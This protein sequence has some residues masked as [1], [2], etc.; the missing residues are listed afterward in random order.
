MCNKNKEIVDLMKK[1]HTSQVQ[2]ESS[3]FF[4]HFQEVT[5]SASRT[6][7]KWLFLPLLGLI[8]M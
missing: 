7:S 3:P 4:M 1:E 6:L 8:L 2:D 5:N